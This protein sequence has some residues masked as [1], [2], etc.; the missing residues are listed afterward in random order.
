MQLQ[1]AP[2]APVEGIFQ[3]E[4]MKFEQK[5]LPDVACIALPAI[6]ASSLHIQYNMEPLY[7][8]LWRNVLIVKY[9]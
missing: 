1:L 3:N 6:N 4:Q 7:L 2:V 8:L 5:I 9:P